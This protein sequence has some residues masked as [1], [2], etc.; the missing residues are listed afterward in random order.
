MAYRHGVY[1]FEVPT[2]IQP[3]VM[4]DS[5]V[6]VVF[7]TAPIHLAEDPYGVTNEPRLLTTLAEAARAFG[8]N[9]RSPKLWREYTAIQTFFSTFQLYAV[10]P[11]VFV[12]VIDP[13]IHNVRVTGEAVEINGESTVLNV[14]GVLLNTVT[15]RDEIGTE[16]AFGEQVGLAFNRDGLLQINLLNGETTQTLYVDYTRLAPEQVDIM[17]IIGG[18]NMAKSKNEGLEIVEDI[19]TDFRIVPGQIVAPGFSQDPV[20]AAVMETRADN[21]NGHFRAIALIDAPTVEVDRNGVTVNKR[22]QDLA[23]WKNR[24]NIVQK[25]Q[26]LLYPKIALG[27]LTFWYSVQMANLIAWT[28]S[29]NRGIPYES[30]SNNN[31]RANALVNELDKQIKL[32]VQQANMLNGNGIVTAINFNAGWVAWGN[33]TAT[34]PGNT[35]VKDNILSIRRMFN[36]LGNTFVLTF[37]S[38]ISDPMTRRRIDSIVDSA[39]IWL[40]GLAAQEFITGGRVEFHEQDNPITS[41]MNGHIAFRFMVT[42][43]SPMIAIDFIMEYDPE[44]LSRLF[45]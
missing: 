31:I 28:D 44:Y 29:R 20:V 36:W 32:N 38:R 24:N 18:Y 3:P 14:H 42:P 16:L 17:D 41:L 22:W 12:N 37:M 1:I 40:N 45:A 19:F 7:G 21:I 5:A 34:F 30:P 26:V 13:H 43:P 11:I 27:E 35:D 10:A 33:R 15:V 2:S 6:P 9:T 4:V 23:A 39:N 25:Q 8:M